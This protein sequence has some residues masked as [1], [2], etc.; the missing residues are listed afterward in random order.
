MAAEIFDY[1]AI[2]AVLVGMLA[3][4]ASMLVYSVCSPQERLAEISL[5]VSQTR[6]QLLS[7][8]DRELGEVWS[9]SKQAMA[10]SLQRLGMVILP[11][12][13]AVLPMLLLAGLA[14]HVLQLSDRSFA[15]AGTPWKTPGYCALWIPLAL[16][17]LLMKMRF[18]IR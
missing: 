6:T 12:I 13:L 11:T 8:D 1:S 17:A 3:G 9:L 14:D 5:Q 15:I 2:C 4:A 7:V 10:C 16:S 18:D